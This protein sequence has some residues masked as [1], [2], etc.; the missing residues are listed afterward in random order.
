[1]LRTPLIQVNVDSIKSTVSGYLAL[2]QDQSL[3][4]CG[5]RWYELNRDGVLYSFSRFT[6]SNLRIQ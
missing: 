5:R 2:G 1:V 6:V 4:D 3:A